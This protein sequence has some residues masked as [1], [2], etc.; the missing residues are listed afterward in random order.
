MRHGA[1]APR[2]RDDDTGASA[3]G[4]AVPETRDHPAGFALRLARD[5]EVS[6]LLARDPI[7]DSARYR[8]EYSDF[9]RGV[10]GAAASAALPG[11]GAAG[12]A[13]RIDPESPRNQRHLG[14][15]S[16]L[17]QRESRVRG[18]GGFR[19]C[20]LEYDRARRDRAHACWRHNEQFLPPAGLATAAR[21][22]V[23]RIR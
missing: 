5:W 23:H 3:R 15:F 14:Q 2:N 22:L 13:R 18:L 20:R 6:E 19:K 1:A 10:R 9:Q 17:A 11:W 21:P 12:L 16:A 7:D 8:R 4:L